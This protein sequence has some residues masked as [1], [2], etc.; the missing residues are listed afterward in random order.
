ME[1]RCTCGARPPEDARFCHKCGRPLFEPEPGELDTAAATV[2]AEAAGPLPPPLPTQ[3]VEISFHNGPAVR[4]CF[5]GATMA[6][7]LAFVQMPAAIEWL[8]LPALLSGAGFLS[9]WIYQR[10]TH[11]KVTGLGGLRMGWMAGIFIFCIFTVLMTLQVVASMQSQDWVAQVVKQMHEQGFNEANVKQFEEA[12]KTPGF[13]GSWM[14]LMLPL[15]FI[16]FTLLSVTGGLLGARLLRL[17]QQ[18]PQ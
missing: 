16:L 1:L 8:W 7:V 11:E 3:P 9:V 6:C 14:L 12:L 10:H 4:A 5:W 13:L 15:G 2:T 17:K 18:Q